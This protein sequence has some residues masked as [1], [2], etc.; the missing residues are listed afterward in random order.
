LSGCR[1][2]AIKK[3]ERNQKNA[4]K[5]ISWTDNLLLAV[6]VDFLCTPEKKMSVKR[7]KLNC[8]VWFSFFQNMIMA[9]NGFN[10]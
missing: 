9:D 4:P 1:M 6:V 2:T 7:F 5:D 3:G 8:S 10:A